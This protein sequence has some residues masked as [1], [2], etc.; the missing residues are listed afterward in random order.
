MALSV[1]TPRVE[2]RYGAESASSF[3]IK[4]QSKTTMAKMTMRR[5]RAERRVGERALAK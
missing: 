1:K 3:G 4:S 5:A 2:S